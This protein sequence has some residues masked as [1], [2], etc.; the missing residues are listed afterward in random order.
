MYV[1]DFE[2]FD[3]NLVFLSFASMTI[4]SCIS[5]IHAPVELITLFIIICFKLSDRFVYLVLC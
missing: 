4:A 3:I 1:N 2:V 5:A